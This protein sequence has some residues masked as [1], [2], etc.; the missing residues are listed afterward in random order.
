MSAR[1]YDVALIGGG[2]VGL[3]TARALLE[4]LQRCSLVVLEA[5]PRL[6]AHQSG[7]NSGVI[8]SGLYYRPGSLKARTCVEGRR[9]L[10]RFLEEQQIPHERCGKLVI[11][12]SERELPILADLQRRGHMNGLQGLRWLRSGE[13]P[14]YEPHARG[15]AA[16]WVPEAGITDFALVAQALARDISQR[17]GE[18]RTSA[19]ALRVH[20][21]SSEIIVETTTGEVRCRVLVGCAGLQ[22][23]RV[24]R[25]CG[26]HP[27]LRIIP[28]RGDYYELIPERRALVRNLIYPV[29]DPEL[30]FLGVHFT[31]RVDGRV[32]VGP[33]AALAFKRE[34]YT[35]W[36]ISARDVGEM[37]AFSGFWR[38]IA[39]Y[40]RVG[41]RE[42][43]LS[44]S[45][46]A[47]ARALERL[48]P[49]IRPQDLRPAPSG[50]RAQAVNSSGRLVDDFHILEAE[51]MVHVLN[52]PSPA[53]TA[54]LRIGEIIAA[55][56]RAHLEG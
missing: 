19:R 55:R 9:A 40:G 3:A 48:V 14:D 2:L 34:G 26:L 29:P 21:R 56:V 27:D 28:F 18:V 24:A 6:A 1:L 49:D 35:R 13:I 51:R 7:R 10:Y 25:L 22:A 33:N 8:H 4:S 11:A 37:F 47:F 16:L 36:S 32:E 15:L 20:R 52:A 50:V 17:G 39:R 44:F 46:R 53:A 54:S 23:D 43:A 45:R 38:L 5:E 41:L 31:R 12:T 30:P 42:M